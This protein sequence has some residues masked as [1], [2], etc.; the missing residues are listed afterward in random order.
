M[1]PVFQFFLYNITLWFVLYRHCLKS[2]GSSVH[3]ENNDFNSTGLKQL[4]LSLSCVSNKREKK[5]SPLWDNSIVQC[6]STF[7]LENKNNVKTI[8]SI[9]F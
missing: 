3:I 6:L 9:K 7:K 8:Q 1:T 2:F 4:S 5:C